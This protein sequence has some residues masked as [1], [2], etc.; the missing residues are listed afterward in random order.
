MFVW[1]HLSIEI[2]SY[3]SLDFW[4]DA[5]AHVANCVLVM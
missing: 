5:N 3:P 1:L 2:L 4:A